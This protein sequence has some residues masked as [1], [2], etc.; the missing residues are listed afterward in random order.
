MFSLGN[1]LKPKGTLVF[2]DDMRPLLPD[3][4]INNVTSE[5]LRASLHEF[6]NVHW[7]EFALCLL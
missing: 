2:D 3:V 1:S 5:H 4:D 6:L 7:G